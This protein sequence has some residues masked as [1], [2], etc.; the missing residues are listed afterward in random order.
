MHRNGYSAICEIQH[1][2]DTEHEEQ[3]SF[4]SPRQVAGPPMTQK[5]R[6]LTKKKKLNVS[7]SI[8][9]SLFIYE[10]YPESVRKSLLCQ[11]TEC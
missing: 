2:L 1:L 5:K 9:G 7:Q 6:T 4:P 3:T 8:K 11:I 10:F